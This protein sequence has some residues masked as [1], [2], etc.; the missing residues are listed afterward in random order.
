E[1]AQVELLHNA[2][3]RR[4][5][6]VVRVPAALGRLI[7]AS[8]A[9]VVGCDA[10]SLAGERRDQLAVEERPRRLAVQQQD[11]FARALVDVV[12]PQAVLLDVV[13]RERERGKP[14]EPFV[15][16]A[17]GVDHR[18]SSS[19]GSWITMRSVGRCGSSE[20]TYERTASSIPTS[21][22]ACSDRN[23]RCSSTWWNTSAGGSR[24][25]SASGTAATVGSKTRWRQ[26]DATADSASG[27]PTSRSR[28]S[29]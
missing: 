3:D 12:Q 15:G 6:A 20:A 4:G 29:R 9:E 2:P 28:A 8:E 5:V 19:S 26:S 10:A 27:R 22:F 21:C 25:W 23:H 17:V 7:R 14:L 16:R 13:R 24:P 18:Y 1:P 11:R